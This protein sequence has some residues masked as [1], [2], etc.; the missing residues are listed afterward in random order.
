MRGA[1]LVRDL[2]ADAARRGLSA[3]SPFLRLAACLAAR[4]TLYNF[5]NR[6]NRP[7]VP[8][9]PSLAAEAGRHRFTRHN[10]HETASLLPPSTLRRC[11]KRCH[12]LIRGAAG[13]RLRLPR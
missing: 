6:L 8:M 10:R 2:S 3:F 11:G 13:L 12:D 7:I 9:L 5:Y 1:I 4:G